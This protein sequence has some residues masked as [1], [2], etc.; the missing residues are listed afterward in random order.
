MNT[1]IKVFFVLFREKKMTVVIL[2]ACV[3]LFSPPK[4]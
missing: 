2:K 1:L 4:R 3:G